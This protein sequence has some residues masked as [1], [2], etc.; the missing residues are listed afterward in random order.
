MSLL[1][2]ALKKAADEKKKESSI[3]PANKAEKD[4]SDNAEDMD[5][6][7][8]LVQEKSEPEFPEVNQQVNRQPERKTE[9]IEEPVKK[10]QDLELELEPDTEP[11]PDTTSV[12]KEEIAAQ[13]IDDSG[14]GKTDSN[15]ISKQFKSDPIS[16]KEESVIAEPALEHTGEIKQTAIDPES[17][18]VPKREQVVATELK[19]SRDMEALSAMINKNHQSSANS[20]RIF[21]LSIISIIMLLLF[22]SGLYAYFMLDNVKTNPV[23]LDLTERKAPAVAEKRL[24]IVD[25]TSQKAV[26]STSLLMQEP[27]VT[28]AN[29]SNQV[30]SVKPEVRKPLAKKQIQIKRKTTE[31]PI[32]VLLA[33]AYAEFKKSEYISSEK[34]YKKVIYRDK[35]N[36]D[37]LL[38]LAAIAVKQNRN[39]EAKDI[40][41]KLLTL[42]PKDSY[43]KAGLSALIN[44]RNAQ[45]N[46]SQLKIMLREQPNAGHLYFALG[47]LLLNQ[48]RYAE[49]QTAFFNAWSSN[50][51]NTDYAYNLAVS[52]DHLGKP[53][54]AAEFYQL[55]VKLYEKSAGNVSVDDVKQRIKEIEGKHNG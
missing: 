12:L 42:D 30:A 16:S 52:L 11:V 18:P 49:A 20:R 54:H 48:K 17:R 31:D 10:A 35:N 47:N 19:H 29:S 4:D 25:N 50:K 43:A 24:K 37:A 40:Y 34:I 28:P 41:I 51:S 14:L 55:T 33:Q 36:H 44:Q 45:L 39:N 38:G 32:G 7:L 15:S 2:D 23:N 5:L 1:L 13:E 26:D 3:A 46:E 27:A 8:D 9:G 21:K 53:E 6:D 22:G